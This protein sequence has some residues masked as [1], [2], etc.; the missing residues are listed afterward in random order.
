M[1]IEIFDLERIQSLYENKVDY[2]L[3]ET[4]L[5]PYNLKELFDQE[6]IDQLAAVRLGYGQTDG[7]D[8]LKETISRLYPGAG[9]ANVLVTNGS[10]EANFIFTWSRLEPGDELV[11]M[12][13]NYMQIWGLARSFGIIVKPFHLKE[14]LD[15]GLDFDELRQQMTS[16]TKVIALCNPNN[17]TGAVL[18]EADMNRVVDLADKA[19]AWLYVDE[20]Y[21]GAE[22]QGQETPTFYGRYDKVVVN[23]GL[24]KAYG[25]PGLRIGW[26]VGPGEMIATGWA[27]HDY[28]TIST[29]ILSQWIAHRVLQKEMRLK[30]LNR[31][32]KMLRENLDILKS[33]VESHPDIFRRFIPPKAGAM[34]FVRYF[35][36]INSR[37]LTTRLRQEKSVFVID[38]DCFGM[39]HYIRIGF[40]S[41]KDYLLAGLERIRRFLKKI[42]HE[43]TRRDTK[44]K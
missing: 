29:G 39:D 16:K 9:P 1:N 31:N 22:L 36:D 5:H 14:E 27:Y 10:A 7:A 13:P 34:A 32:R 43:V 6:D 28:T 33:W 25:M 30:I 19:D 21:R 3:T 8:E 40:G 2:N 35:M 11:L 12:L 24:S 20:I 44:E 18:S 23:S 17:P 37:E 42:S 26:L 4:G 38:G 41:E 15:W